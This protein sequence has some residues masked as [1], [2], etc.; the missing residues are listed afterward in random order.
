MKLVL[1]IFAALTVI[2][3]LLLG[4]LA[5]YYWATYIDENISSGSA[6]GFI[7]GSSKEDAVMGFEKLRSEYPDMHV[8]VSYGERAGDNFS[9]PAIPVSIGNLKTHNKWDILLNGRYEFSNSTDLYFEDG[10]LVKIYRHRQYFE[11]P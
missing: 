6:Y 2:P 9:I 4:G 1:K 8:Y 5:T 7:I 11:L 10:N 3:V